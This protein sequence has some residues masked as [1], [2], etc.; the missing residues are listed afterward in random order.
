[1][2]LFE[3][4]TPMRIRPG[5]PLVVQCVHRD[6]HN[7]INLG[8][9][10]LS[11]TDDPAAVEAERQRWTPTE[12]GDARDWLAAEYAA[13]GDAIRAK[14]HQADAAA[15]SLARARSLTESLLEASPNDETLAGFLADLLLADTSTAWNVP[16]F[17]EMPMSRGGASLE[18]QLDGSIFVT[19]K[20]PEE[21]LYTVVLPL[22]SGNVRAL[23]LQTLADERLPSA[24]SGRSPVNGNFRLGELSLSV[25][26]IE[27]PASEIQ[28][29]VT[30]AHA[31]FAGDPSRGVNSAID[32]DRSTGWS[33][34]PRQNLDHTA[35][36]EF[37]LP[38]AVTEE[39]W[40]LVVRLDTGDTP[41]PHHGLGR[42]RLSVTDDP[43]SFTASQLQHPWLQL[44]AAFSIEGDL[45]AATEC[46]LR[47][48]DGGADFAERLEL[49][50]Q[51]GRYTSDL[52]HLSALRPE[53][54]LYE[55]LH[56]R[57]RFGEL[58]TSI[59][60]EQLVTEFLEYL[61]ETT[62][63]ELKLLYEFPEFR[64]VVEQDRFE[65]LVE[66][67]LAK[68]SP[69]VRQQV[70]TRQ[71]PVQ[72]AGQ[73]LRTRE[74]LAE[75]NTTRQSTDLRP[76]FLSA[77]RIERSRDPLFVTN[78][79]NDGRDH[80]I[81]LALTRQEFDDLLSSLPDELQPFSIE[82]YADGGS[83]LIALLCVEQ[84]TPAPWVLHERLN[85][86]ATVELAD[87][88][89]TQG[90]RPTYVNAY[91]DGTLTTVWARD[92]GV[93]ELLLG[94]TYQDLQDL[95]TDRSDDCL[96]LFLDSHFDGR[97]RRYSMI[98]DEGVQGV[99]WVFSLL[100]PESDF[101]S[102][103]DRRTASGWKPVATTES[104]VGRALDGSN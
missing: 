104:P 4:A 27:D 82:E 89:R 77:S 28:V 73:S 91:P 52:S 47:V 29:P 79:T 10:R 53:D 23:R 75:L 84:T 66:S 3:L 43:S 14:D 57:R 72:F 13:V 62:E 34:G 97:R 36:F 92:D 15:E 2:A 11:V 58:T 96:P 49:I 100:L 61:E 41:Y 39:D 42:F 19:G 21:D 101:Q 83:P 80:R 8:R 44:G 51:I 20:N 69:V 17:V 93:S 32:G 65:L 18:P 46:F 71:P 60:D 16:E 98:I 25:R 12:S 85:E 35:I 56:F 67:Q 50:E 76:T 48:L 37:Q 81:E 7:G 86:S 63:I 102:T 1:M 31:D 54:P 26:S 87:T 55:W 78:W 64:S 5:Q 22:T 9:F 103:F 90:F 40:Q 38:P 94:L 68:S 6:V 95:Q 59:H 70:W 33:A 30:R 99:E 74:N 24:G 45:E 88:M